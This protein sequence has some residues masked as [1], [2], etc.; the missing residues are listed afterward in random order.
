[1]KKLMSGFW[2]GSKLNNGQSSAPEPQPTI[3]KR[4]SDAHPTNPPKRQRC[5]ADA[6]H[7]VHSVPSSSDMADQPHLA[8]RKGPQDSQSVRSSGNRR[9]SGVEELRSLDRSIGLGTK[10]RS[11]HKPS[12]PMFVPIDDGKGDPRNTATSSSAYNSKRSLR[13]LRKEPYS[14]PVQ[15]DEDATLLKGAPSSGANG[16]S[17][18]VSGKPSYTTARF[19]HAVPDMSSEDELSVP[20]PTVSQPRPAKQ[21]Q[22][23]SEEQAKSGRKRAAGSDCDSDERKRSHVAKRRPEISSR[24]DMQRTQFSSKT[25]ARTQSG[26]EA[27]R[28]SKAVC[29]PTYVY[30][31]EGTMH[32][33]MP[34]ASNKPCCLV[35]VTTGG[36]MQFEAVDETGEVIPE[37]EWITPS[38]HTFKKITS[39]P[40]SPIVRIMKSLDYTRSLSTGTILFVQFENSQDAKDYVRYCRKANDEIHTESGTSDIIGLSNT[41]SVRIERIMKSN[42]RK[43]PPPSTTTRQADD[44]QLLERRRN[45]ERKVSARLPQLQDQQA[46]NMASLQ[47]V[48]NQMKDDDTLRGDAARSG[49]EPKQILTPAQ[50]K[51][52]RDVVEDDYDPAHQQNSH[53]ITEMHLRTPARLNGH[54]Q[55]QRSLR[56]TR[57]KA[58]SPSPV[59][60]RW[61]M[62]HQDWAPGWKTDLVY[63]RTT[64]GKGDIERLDEG[65]LLNDE[66]ISFYIKYLHKQLEKKDEQMANKVYVFNS[67]FWDKLKPRKGEINYDGVKNWTAKVDLLSFDYIIV[68]IN[69][70]AHWYLAI[71]C[72][73]RGLLHTEKPGSEAD[74]AIPEEDRGQAG[75]GAESLADESLTQI[76]T[77]VSHISIDDEPVDSAA[78]SPKENGKSYAEKNAKPSKKGSGPRKYDPKAPKVITLDSLGGP[79]SSVVTALKRYL[80][81]E[82]KHKKGANVNPPN[83]FGTHARDIP[84]QPNFTD[85]GVYLLGYMQEFMKDP[86]RFA[87]RILQSE[88]RD[89]DVNAPALRSEIRELI[90]KLQKEHQYGEEQKR[91]QKALASRKQPPKPQI[92]GASAAKTPS[93][94]VNE[95]PTEQTPVSVF[96][97]GAHLRQET[98]LRATSSPLRDANKDARSAQQDIHSSPP[99]AA[100]DGQEAGLSQSQSSG[101]D[102]VGN[103]NN[104]SMVVN[105]D[106]SIER[107]DSESVSKPRATPQ[108]IFK[109]IEGDGQKQTPAPGRLTGSRQTPH[110]NTKTPAP[111]PA[112]YDQRL[113]EPIPSSPATSDTATDK[114]NTSRGG[115]S[116]G[117][118]PGNESHVKSPYFL[119]TAPRTGS[120]RKRGPVRGGVTR[121][122]GIPSSDTE[123]GGS[124]K[125]K[126]SPTIDLTSE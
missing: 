51:N 19:G 27:L 93:E 77:D 33:T 17:S 22:N 104:L 48:R 16:A 15:D 114:G 36:K 21:S 24:A 32:E 35:P 78:K 110:T 47:P 122:E 6:S 71:I 84:C 57:A 100:D 46:R 82:I 113:L 62:V 120:T 108:K 107:N 124:S 55:P 74:A 29:E 49:N 44:I 76:S 121:R 43:P 105:L 40:N 61:T 7:D 56:S 126:P 112:M 12:R 79:H 1:M 23:I 88:K 95:Q 91:R 97:S 67:F 66:I 25:T 115:V 30:P 11:R 101:S 96:V 60:E 20:R 73:A 42:M 109:S 90:F 86:D 92:P 59:L 54:E 94:A 98:P 99:Q 118:A 2:Y 10:K 45:A 103:L 52:I 83:T 102:T 37:L 38:I 70:N 75:G 18:R 116:P 13:H 85:C 28:I 87:R 119:N 80:C 69:E 8:G 125:G 117:Q 123:G 64:V 9:S 39:N 53:D 81:E 58:R 41:M 72:N 4:P 63:E 5:E 3:A 106:R 89:W 26:P 14:D 111:A 31:A 34:G 50:E 68:P 65:Q